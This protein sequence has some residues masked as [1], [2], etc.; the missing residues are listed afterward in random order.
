VLKKKFIVLVCVV[1]LAIAGGVAWA[2]WQWETPWHSTEV[3]TAPAVDP[4][5]RL[6]KPITDLAA[7][8][9]QPYTVNVTNPNAFPV[10]VR[11]I[12]GHSLTIR[13]CGQYSVALKIPKSLQLPTSKI[14]L[15]NFIVAARS[16]RA[17]TVSIEMADWALPPC[18][19]RTLPFTVQ[20][21]G[22]QVVSS[23]G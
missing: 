20:A 8:V 2:A 10:R 11:Y 23:K 13:G 15:R 5:I 3:K 4:T 18:M 1:L 19:G 7:G 12:D 21:K 9:P 16:T 6:P 17:L 14:E 22:I